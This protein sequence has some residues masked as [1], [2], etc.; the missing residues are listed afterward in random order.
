MKT[1]L[2]SSCI[3]IVGLSLSVFPQAKDDPKASPKPVATP[4]PAS[5]SLAMT[6]SELKIGGQI[7]E[8]LNKSV[9]ALN[10]TLERAAQFQIT[11][12]PKIDDPSKSELALSIAMVARNL[13][14]TQGAFNMWKAEV[15]KAHDCAGCEIENG[16]LVKKESEKK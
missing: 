12:D 10:G 9:Q 13:R 4:A 16:K 5:S 3:F 6:A 2:L 1:L 8:A 14:E 7:T 11:G 15:Q